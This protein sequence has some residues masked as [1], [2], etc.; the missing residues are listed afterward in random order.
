MVDVA[1]DE[2]K[3]YYYLVKRPIL[4]VKE[5]SLTQYLKIYS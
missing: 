3:T 4:L 5:N 2:V 1:N